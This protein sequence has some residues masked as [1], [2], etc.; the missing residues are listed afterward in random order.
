MASKRKL[1]LADHAKPAHR[2]ERRQIFIRA[3]SISPYTR[4]LFNHR[5]GH[6]SRTRPAFRYVG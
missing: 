4:A 5:D 1:Y 2:G 3:T 6:W